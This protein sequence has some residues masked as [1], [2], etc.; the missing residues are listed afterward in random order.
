[1]LNVDRNRI[2]KLIKN[3]KKLYDFMEFKIEGKEEST[4]LLS[5]AKSFD[6]LNP[7]L[8]KDTGETYCNIREMSNHTGIAFSGCQY[9]IKRGYNN[10]NEKIEKMSKQQFLTD[11][12][13]IK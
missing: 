6:N 10:K 11:S 13:Y 8:N 9:H 3:N 5:I 12:N 4:N 2:N 7:I 1:M